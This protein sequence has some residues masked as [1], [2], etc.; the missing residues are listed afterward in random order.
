VSR[1]R[2]AENHRFIGDQEHAVERRMLRQADQVPDP[3]HMRERARAISATADRHLEEAQRLGEESGAAGDP[4]D[5][6]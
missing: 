4:S 3:G 5:T 6:P 1:K 2:L